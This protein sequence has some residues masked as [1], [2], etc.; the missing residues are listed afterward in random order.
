MDIAVKVVV[1]AGGVGGARMAL[2]FAQVL[3]GEDLTIIVNVGDDARFHGLTVCPD[4]DTVLYTLSGVVD[5]EQAWGVQADS[6][7][8]LDVLRRL[9]SPGSWMKLGDSDL[10][11]HIYRSAR[12]A[13]G[14]TLTDVMHDVARRFEVPFRLLP[15]SDAP[16]PTVVMT[17]AGPLPFQEWFVKGKA[18]PPVQSLDLGAARHADPTAEVIYALHAADLVVIAPS[19]PFLSIH[20]ILE[21]RGMRQLLGQIAAPR[22]AVSPLIGGKAV[23]GPLDSLMRSL[24]YPLSNVGIANSYA[25]DI[26]ALVF[27]ESDADDVGAVRALGL[28][29]GLSTTLIREAESATRLAEW[30]L[31]F[32]ATVRVRRR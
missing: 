31:D 30:L 19:N 22:V 8:A 24:S 16:C 27:D 6:T 32:S 9:E 17:D 25:G 29:I 12:L 3:R 23:K 11:L 1:L 2:G 4:L 10:G 28:D 20:P 15:A 13:T 26:D 21:L 7:K 18:N 14:C 5:R